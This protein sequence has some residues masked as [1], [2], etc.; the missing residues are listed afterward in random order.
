MPS[1]WGK[2]AY[3]DYIAAHCGYSVTSLGPLRAL[4]SYRMQSEFVKMLVWVISVQPIKIRIS[5]I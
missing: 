1:I 5:N 2:I 3:R 4:N